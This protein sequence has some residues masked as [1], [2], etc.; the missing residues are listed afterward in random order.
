MNGSP[1]EKPHL[2]MQS[3]VM[4]RADFSQERLGDVLKEGGDELTA[5][6]LDA[7]R[8]SQAMDVKEL[9]EESEFYKISGV[10][11]TL[12][13]KLGNLRK[14]TFGDFIDETKPGKAEKYR[15]Q[16]RACCRMLHKGI[17]LQSDVDAKAV[18]VIQSL[19]NGYMAEMLRLERDLESRRQQAKARSA[20]RRKGDSKVT[21]TVNDKE[22][23]LSMP[24]TEM[25]TWREIIGEYLGEMSVD[26]GEDAWED[27]HDNPDYD[28]YIAVQNKTYIRLVA[29]QDGLSPVL[30]LLFAAPLEK[31][32]YA[33]WMETYDAEVTVCAY[34]EARKALAR[35]VQF[36]SE[37]R[38]YTLDPQILEFTVTYEL[39]DQFSHEVTYVNDNRLTFAQ[40]LEQFL[41]SSL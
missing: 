6:L 4:S 1:A 39:N 20:D 9:K 23:G 36:L 38:A 24:K 40:K 30:F 12:R 25:A 16:F 11:S 31:R 18:T 26:P 7:S 33:I 17:E 37:N 41:Q 19:L 8:R 22:A 14:L 5:I 3:L 15:L 27:A 21:Q 28:A 32:H 10:E 29:E 2:V 35:I 34:E 13:K